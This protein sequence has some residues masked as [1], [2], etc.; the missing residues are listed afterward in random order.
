MNEKPYIIRMN[1][2]RYQQILK[3]TLDAEKRST[4]ERLLTS[5]EDALAAAE[6]S[7]QSRLP[8]W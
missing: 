4:V 8:S 1:I 7:G 2:A 6:Q 3:S 5:A